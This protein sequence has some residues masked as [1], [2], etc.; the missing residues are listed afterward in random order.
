MA[1]E[2][3]FTAGERT[4]RRGLIRNPEEALVESGNSQSCTPVILSSQT[5]VEE[6]LAVGELVS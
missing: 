4:S 2:E 6:P 5:A 1:L 3:P